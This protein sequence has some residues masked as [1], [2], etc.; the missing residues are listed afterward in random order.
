MLRD[1]RSRL[2]I[3]NT[4]RERP[5]NNSRPTSTARISTFRRKRKP[6]WRDPSDPHNLDGDDDGIA[7]EQ[8]PPRNEGPGNGSLEGL[9]ES[10]CE[11]ILETTRRA[12]ANQYSFSSE[13]IE[14]CLAREVIVGSI[15]K[16][17]LPGTGGPFPLL[18]LGLAAVA[19]GEV[20]GIAI[21]R[22]S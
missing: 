3:S 22:R 7:C 5:P 14:Q 15:P 13:R 20:V 19:L 11:E 12:G 21:L 10:R 1:K 4:T 18:V 8:L 9:A 6:S 17:T 2:L 16:G